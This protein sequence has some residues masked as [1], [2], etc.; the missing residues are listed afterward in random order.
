MTPENWEEV[1]RG[2]AGLKVIFE[3]SRDTLD[4][5]FMSGAAAFG[6]YTA[7]LDLHERVHVLEEAQRRDQNT[8]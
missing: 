2:Y 7:L 8:G 6:I 1:K 3:T 5:S 4:K